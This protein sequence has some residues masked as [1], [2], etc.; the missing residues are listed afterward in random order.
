[1]TNTGERAGAEVAQVYVSDDHAKVER[2]IKELKGF[3][4]V[5]LQP[6]ET[7]HVSVSLDGRSF[8]YYDTEAKGWHIAPGKFGILVG[9]SSESLDLK[10]SVEISKEAASNATF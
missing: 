4:R 3:D 5:L 9:D 6:G 1:V 10:G 2:P 7:K 8:A